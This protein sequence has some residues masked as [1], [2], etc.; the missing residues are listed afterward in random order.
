MFASAIVIMPPAQTPVR[1]AYATVP[2][3]RIFYRGTGGSGVPV[4]LLHAASSPGYKRLQV[5]ANRKSLLIQCPD[6][7]T[8]FPCQIGGTNAAVHGILHQNHAK[9]S[10]IRFIPFARFHPPGLAVRLY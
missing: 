6:A 2:G 1:E 10:K 5:V 9:N 7:L 3:A 4:I 8:P